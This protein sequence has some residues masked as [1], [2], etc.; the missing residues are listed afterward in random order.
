MAKTVTVNNQEPSWYV[1]AR[2]VVVGLFVAILYGVLA[3]IISKYVVDPL[4]CGGGQA[5]SCAQSGS[6]STNI[7]L[8]LAAIGGLALAIR[9]ELSRPLF[10]V[11]FATALLWGFGDI[12]AG[13][14]WLEVFGWAL[15]LFTAV[16]VLSAWMTRHHN[17][18]ALTVVAVVIFVV[19]RIL[20]SL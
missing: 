4:T 20:L 6:I 16:Y 10:V 5:S 9:L 15:L 17:L 8:V 12:T 7:A 14:V 1:W 19:E 11:L 13:L 18:T 3:Y 2:S